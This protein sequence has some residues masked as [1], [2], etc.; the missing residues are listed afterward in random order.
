MPDDGLTLTSAAGTDNQSLCVGSDPTISSLTTITYQ[1]S[2]GAL[3]AN[4]VGLPPGFS[5]SYSAT[6]KVYSIFGTAVSDVVSNPTIFNYTVT[7]SGTCA[8]V[9]EVGA[10]TIRPK[11]KVTVTSASP[12]LD[13]IVCEN[14][15]I[16]PI[17]FDISGSATNASGSG[18][19][20][21]ILS[22]IHI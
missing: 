4:I 12:T 21:G 9:T 8:A 13:Q 17:T 15:A 7:T 3:S 20:P 16:T 6:T 5:T 22:L 1:I 2:G 11:A 18:L 19:P 14:G 10:I